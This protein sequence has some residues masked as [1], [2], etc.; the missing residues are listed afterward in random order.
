MSTIDEAILN[1]KPEWRAII[2]ASRTTTPT[3]TDEPRR[4]KEPAANL[5]EKAYGRRLDELK[6]DGLVKW[7]AFNKIRLRIADGEKAAWYKPDF[8]VEFADGRFEMHETKGF[9]RPRAVLALKVAAGQFPMFQFVLVKRCGDGW[10][11]EP[12]NGAER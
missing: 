2:A 4:P 5:T 10:T 9:E 7:W 8:F 1:R 12:F 3:V 6:L 11:Y